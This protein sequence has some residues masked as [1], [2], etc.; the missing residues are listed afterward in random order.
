[1]TAVCIRRSW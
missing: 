1:M